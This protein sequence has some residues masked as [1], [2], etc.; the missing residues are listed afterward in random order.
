MPARTDPVIDDHLRRLVVDEGAAGV[1]VAAD[2]VEHAGRQELGR[3]SASS[4]VDTGVVSDGLSTTVLPAA[5][6][7]RDFQTAMI[8]G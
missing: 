4:S 1:A 5:I 3:D 6:A 8:S 7:G 2:H